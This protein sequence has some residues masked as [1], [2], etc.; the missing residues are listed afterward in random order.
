[1]AKYKVKYETN[2]IVNETVLELSTEIAIRN[3]LIHNHNVENPIILEIKEQSVSNLNNV[4]SITENE[5]KPT[6]IYAV[7]TLATALIGFMYLPLL[8]VPICFICSFISYYRL[9][10]NKN[11]EGKGLRL[12]GAIINSINIIY[13]FYK[14]QLGPFNPN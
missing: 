12:A 14:F 7:I 10:D 8:F 1:M 4:E 13:L 9:K 3:L 2:N 5:S 6:D 11:L